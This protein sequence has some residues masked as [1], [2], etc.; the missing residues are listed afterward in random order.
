MLITVLRFL[1]IISPFPFYYFLWNWPQT[2]VD[3]FPDK[4]SHSMSLISNGLKVLQFI[5]LGTTWHASRIQWWNVVLILAGQFLNVRVYQ[6]LGE[7]GVYYGVRFGYT[8]PWCTEFPYVLPCSFHG[9][10]QLGEEE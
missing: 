2:F 7:I 3:A 1:A 8:V 10:R 6:L 4:P 9:D 5:A